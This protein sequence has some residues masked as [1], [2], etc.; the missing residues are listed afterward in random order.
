MPDGVAATE[1]HPS[2]GRI[3]VVDDEPAIVES[4]RLLLESEGYQASSAATAGECLESIASEPQDLVLLDLMLPDRPGLEVLHEI[5]KI[6]GALPVVMLTAFGSIETA[7][8]ATRLGATNF[9]TKPW[10]NRQL[11]LEIRQILERRSLEAENARLRSQLGSS[12]SVEK[13]VRRSQAMQNVFALI[14]RVAPTSSTVLISGESGTGKELVARAVH[15]RSARADKP[16][17]TV[18]SETIPA[19]ILE[20]TLFGHVKGSFVG[21]ARHREGCFAIANEGTIFLDEVSTLTA[22]A[23][24][25]LL[26][27]I[28]EREFVPVGSHNPVQ[29]DVRIVA[30]TNA[31]LKAAVDEG[32]FREDLYYRLN[33]I[34]IV[35]PPLRDRTDDIA[36]LVDEFL[37]HFCRREKHHFLD[38]ERNPTLRFTPEALRI[39]QA[40]S[41][42][43]N[44]R[45]LRNTVERAVVLANREE[46]TPDVLPPSVLKG[47]S[48]SSHPDPAGF[49]RRSG[50]SLSE[51]VE[52]FERRLL[53]DELE[54]HGYNQTET[55]K[56]LQVPLSTL[57]QKIRRLGIAVKG[58]RTD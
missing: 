10:N 2:A 4:L 24:S 17:V 9:L 45:E 49:Q 42:P 18:N 11:L 47:N 33:V 32:R 22:E 53:L 5:R 52:G 19:E 43:G 1:S 40:H 50:A 26:H 3:L 12:G 41:W 23:Q 38:H 7:V 54:K 31:D 35:V 25:K 21:A 15:E 27:V 46:L 34:G 56:G 14:D 39:L 57:N 8:E 16:F 13:L 48:Q 20:S 58:R 28:E 44:V 55:A 6:D 30:A 29:A 51:M 37:T 36:P